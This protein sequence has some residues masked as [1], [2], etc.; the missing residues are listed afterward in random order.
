MRLTL[1][2]AGCAAIAL[3]GSAAAEQVTLAPISYSSAF[4]ATLTRDFGAAEGVYLSEDV[5]QAISQA[6]AHRGVAV[7]AGGLTIEVS[8]VSADP[9]RPTLQQL[10][11]HTNL[12]WGRSASLGGAE[13]HAT[14]RSADGR[15]LTEVTHRHY[16]TTFADYSGY[17][18]PPTWWTAERAIDR[19][20]EKV[21]DAYEAQTHAQ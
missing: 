6:L 9:N 21:A 10:F 2:L 19:F 16:D 11:R 7:G 1:A 4:E 12:D 17:P 20:A 18:A 5:T 15:A 8:I 14:I 3:A 13:L